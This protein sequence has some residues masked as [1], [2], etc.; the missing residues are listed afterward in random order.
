MAKGVPHPHLG[1]VLPTAGMCASVVPFV[2]EGPHCY[3]AEAATAPQSKQGQPISQAVQEATEQGPP[4][5]I[6]ALL[7]AQVKLARPRSS[8][9]PREQETTNTGKSVY[10]RW[11]LRKSRKCTCS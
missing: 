10:S 7:T 11:T 5:C 1:L 8:L 3:S 4:L 2:L 9:H 6:L